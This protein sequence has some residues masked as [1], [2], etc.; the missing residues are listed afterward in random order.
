MFARG[1]HRPAGAVATG[2]SGHVDP[3]GPVSAGDR[4]PRAARGGRP[5]AVA[6]AEI[7]QVD[8]NGPVS[9]GDRSPDAVA[10]AREA[11]HISGGHTRATVNI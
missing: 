10:A 6:T 4:S 1:G 9:A 7:G 5:G 2:E 8:P 11:G 3:N